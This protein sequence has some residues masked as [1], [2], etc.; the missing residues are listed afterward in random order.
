[1][2]SPPGKPL[3]SS[4]QCHSFLIPA[5]L[6]PQ[7]ITVRNVGTMN[8]LW[9]FPCMKNCF[10][11][12]CDQGV[13]SSFSMPFRQLQQVKGEAIFYPY[14]HRE[15][16]WAAFTSSSVALLLF[17]PCPLLGQRPKEASPQHR[18]LLTQREA[19]A[20]TGMSGTLCRKL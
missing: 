16:C 5:S 14:P 6:H 3:M 7:E 17:A 10:P 9:C 8:H 15:R 19:A 13:H 1:M 4:K 12:L 20:G 2:K 18:E 11:Y